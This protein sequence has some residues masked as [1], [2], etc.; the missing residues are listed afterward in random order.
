MKIKCSSV[1]HLC[2]PNSLLCFC[3]RMTHQTLWMD[4]VLRA[5]TWTLISSSCLMSSSYRSAQ[6]RSITLEPALVFRRLRVRLLQR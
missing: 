1:T 2:Q 5:S 6:K 3:Q 4:A